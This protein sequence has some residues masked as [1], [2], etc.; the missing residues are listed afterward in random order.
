MNFLQKPI[1]RC[2]IWSSTTN[3]TSIKLFYLILPISLDY[4]GL[5]TEVKRF[6]LLRSPLGNKTS[7]DQFERREHRSYFLYK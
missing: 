7:K 1:Y 3:A 4:L 2:E 5:P 6:T